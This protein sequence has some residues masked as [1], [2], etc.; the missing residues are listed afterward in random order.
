MN[1]V[2]TL[3][4]GA[5]RRFWGKYYDFVEKSLKIRAII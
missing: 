3:A 1:L 4:L 2:C 5:L